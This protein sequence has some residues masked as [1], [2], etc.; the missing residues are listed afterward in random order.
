MF[1][2]RVELK[3][4]SGHMEKLREHASAEASAAGKL[5]GCKAYSFSEDVAEPGRVL[6]YEE[7]ATRDAFEAYKASPL[8]AAAG[9]WLMPLLAEPP[10]S[11]YY[12]SDDVFTTCAA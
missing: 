8:F 6:L 7:W 3:L 11:A 10:K 9:T 12:E 2:V 5:P 4:K 1:V